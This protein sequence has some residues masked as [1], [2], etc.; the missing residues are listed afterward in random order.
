MSRDKLLSERR[1]VVI[2]QVGV[3]FIIL[4]GLFS[5][6]FIGPKQTANVQ[7]TVDIQTVP[8]KPANEGDVPQNFS[9]VSVRAKAAYI[10][11]VKGQRALYAKNED[12]VLPLASITKLMTA[13]LAYEIASADTDTRLSNKAIAQEGG[14]EGLQ[15][16]EEFTLKNL[17]KIALISSSND[18]AYALGASTGA[19]LGDRDP[20]LQ[21]IQ[22]M[23]IRAEELE[24]DSLN[25]K[26]TTGLDI[27]TNEPGA[28]GSAKDV[29]LLV[30]Y[31]LEQ[32]PE[33]LEATTLGGARIYNTQGEYHDVENTNE[34]LY[35]I[36]NLIGSKTGYTD[37]A[38]GNL[39][40]AF[41]VGMDRPIIVTVL[42]STR[43]ERFTDVIRL[44]N[45]VRA[46][47]SDL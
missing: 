37:L 15:A 24:L 30:E 25:F 2:F 40:V 9:D 33:L 7:D 28:V 1:I 34:A 39:T 10:W 6:I 17:S 38:G 20:A 8:V 32:H 5:A 18:A 27:S 46:N 4:A 11:D 44:V 23:N 29:S 22:G 16:G 47:I 36:P 19:L 45:A 43:D 12:E 21:F 3:L 41:D 13:L 35:A 14:G 26:S 42:G 31:I